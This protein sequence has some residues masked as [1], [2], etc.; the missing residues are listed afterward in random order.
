MN[1]V[2]LY[3]VTAVGSLFWLVKHYYMLASKAKMASLLQIYA[4]SG[5][6]LLKGILS[7]PSICFDLK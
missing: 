4:L 7:C 3:Y 5:S 2:L 6:D 1:K